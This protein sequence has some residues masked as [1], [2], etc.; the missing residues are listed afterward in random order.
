MC[1]RLQD[2]KTEIIRDFKEIVKHHLKVFKDKNGD[3]PATI[4]YYRDGVSEG[5][6]EQVM[7]IER[8]AMVR[9]NEF[10]FIITF[11]L[12]LILSLQ[13]GPFLGCRMSR[14]KTRLRKNR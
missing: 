3:Y 7:A 11:F 4:L 13:Y 9:I 14:S 2:P 10:K 12:L 6:F 8:N 5:Q 1:W